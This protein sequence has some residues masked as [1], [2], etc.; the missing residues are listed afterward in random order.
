MI[1]IYNSS[2]SEIPKPLKNCTISNLTESSFNLYCQQDEECA[3]NK[4]WLE[5]ID[6]KDL[7]VENVTAITPNF[8]VSD[9]HPGTTYYVTVFTTN[10]FGHSLPAMFNITTIE[11]PNIGK[12][13]LFILSKCLLNPLLQCRQSRKEAFKLFCMSI[14]GKYTVKIIIYNYLPFQNFVFLGH[15]SFLKE[16]T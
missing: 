10:K 9:L 2:V 3:D 8:V 7:F 14:I 5:V 12:I 1:Q 16:R 6:S 13:T 11:K 15:G 4:F